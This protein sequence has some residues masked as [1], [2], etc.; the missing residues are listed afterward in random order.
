MPIHAHSI[1]TLATLTA[2]FS[3][4][5]GGMTPYAAAQDLV[6]TSADKPATLIELYS[7]EGC[8]SCPPAEDWLAALKTSPEL[9]KQVVPVAFHVT[10]WDNLGWPDRFAR[11]EYTQRQ[12]SYSARFKE[13]SVYTPEF[14][15][16]AQ[17]WRGFFDKQKIPAADAR[18][19]GVLSL[20]IKDNGAQVEARFAPAASKPAK[21][22]TLQ[23]AWLGSNLASDVQRGE[24]AGHTLRHEFVVLSLVAV[25]LT[26]G[27]TGAATSS[28]LTPKFTTPDKPSAVAAWVIA[29]DGTYIQ[30]TGG[31]LSS[32]A[33]KP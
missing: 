13:N 26:L 14:I 31:W 20:S 27:D 2:L 6:F 7:S 18:P 22:M 4:L 23:V 9:W 17:E 15:V 10:Y 3:G 32:S 11:P 5:L 30:A 29:D 1:F 21:K 33:K 24:N 12:Q 28:A 19:V 8:S 16:N 25:P